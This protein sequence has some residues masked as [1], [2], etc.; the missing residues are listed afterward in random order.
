MFGLPRGDY[1]CIRC[2]KTWAEDAI[3][4]FCKHVLIV[5]DEIREILVQR[6][7]D[8]NLF[9][10]EGVATDLVEVDQNTNWSTWKLSGPK[11]TTKF[12]VLGRY[13]SLLTIT[14]AGAGGLVGAAANLVSPN[15]LSFPALTALIL[16]G[17]A[18]G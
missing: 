10:T 7:Q 14:G 1:K 4:P 18:A 2:G 6:L 12:R 13:R 11:F 3:C 17:A 15:T 8:N 5:P 9:S 16:G